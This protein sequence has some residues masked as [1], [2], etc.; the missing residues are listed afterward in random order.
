[1]L[2]RH[3]IRVLGA[4]EVWLG[5]EPIAISGARQRLIVGALALRPGQVVPIAELIDAVWGEDPPETAWRQVQNSVSLLR[6]V[7]DAATLRSEPPGY[8]LAVE[9]EQI[10]LWRF[11]AGLAQGRSLA[12]EGLPVRAAQ[13]FREA[14]LL[15]RGPAFA[16]LGGNLEQAATQ[17][18]AE[19]LAAQEECLE[20]ELL[21][22]AGD[23]LIPELSALVAENPLRERFAAALMLA[24]YRSG[25]QAE[26]LDVYRAAV[27]AL[28]DEL[29][30]DPGPQLSQRHRQILHADPALLAPEATVAAPKPMQLP[31]APPMFVG[32]EAELEA[33]ASGPALTVISGGAGV[34]KTALALHWGH[35]VSGRFPDGQLYVNLCGFDPDGVAVDPAEAVRGFLDA[36]EVGPQRIPVGLA[37]QA[38][39]LR[40]LLSGKRLLIVLDNARDSDQ[41]RHLL[42]GAPGP[43]VIVTSRNLLTG[44]MTTHGARPLPLDLLTAGDAV[45]LLAGRLGE[46]RV[47]AEPDAVRQIVDAC[48]G[49][50]LALAIVAARAVTH[51][52]W[53][54][55]DLAA[56]LA[57][58]RAR[59]D[60]LA[61]DSAGA[62]VRAV[63]SWS[64]LS[65]HPAAARMFRLLGAHPGPEFNA[66]AAASLAAQA[67]AT[68]AEPATA[69]LNTP[70][71][72]SLASQTPTSLAEPAVEPATASPSEPAASRARR[73]LDELADANLLTQRAPGR[74]V[75]HDLLRLY[76]Q[77]LVATNETAEERLA[78]S[79]RLIDH[80]LHTA[81]QADRRLMPS[82]RPIALP[83]PS[84]GTVVG[85]FADYAQAMAWFTTEHAT[86][87][88]CVTHA[89][90][91]R[92]DDRT[93]RLAWALE[94]YLDIRGHWHDLVSTHDTA[95]AA[96]DRLGDPMGQAHAHRGLA[97]AF[98]PLNRLAESLRQLRLAHELHEQL[99]DTI[100]QADIEVSM[101]VVAN[102]QGDY[103]QAL[104]HCVTA[105]KQYDTANDRL[106][107][108]KAHS[109]MGW[110]HAQL[111]DHQQAIEDC[112]YAL[113]LFE[114]L[115]DPN[116][117][118]ATLDS[119]GFA[120]HGLGD[121][122]AALASYQQALALFR[123][124][125]SGLNMA[126]ALDH[127]AG[128]EEAKGRHEAAQ[129]AW[130]EAVAILED[131]D[132]PD[133]GK[134]RQ[135]LE[136]AS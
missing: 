71:A 20:H 9:P 109:A 128:I 14:L 77:E 72:A 113:S 55:A 79:S 23:S 133:A 7:F 17:L 42:P 18:A 41:L 13:V 75:M 106:G 53:S 37:A 90:A 117:H 69:A 61:A 63:F 58:S 60:L 95:L 107:K 24:L 47:A 119:L 116:W 130:L 82:R 16:G 38:A 135:K 115:D 5:R 97:R 86:L 112:R 127:I 36:F 124:S 11:R 1:M 85:S 22:G 89:S 46:A 121:L 105:A 129:R 87:M 94:I 25:R 96:A 134:I 70:A 51:P 131:L 49:L 32:R 93:W 3:D 44:L 102:R 39:M 4:V 100:G 50:P 65:L 83:P 98:A 59:L 88:A 84:P 108:A 48:A 80:Y 35:S 2:E 8:R 73:L 29:G 104:A 101:A 110:Y 99:G 76:A 10:D 118:A 66:P 68:F 43:T 78:A 6:R 27:E 15:W 123:R 111:G 114:G 52:R 40:S 81:V 132:H 54:L 33:L 92:L 12:A 74:Y 125:G 122:D 28:A 30:V 57:D 62:D 21:A 34:G 31:G 67:P 64:Y 103:V 56:A 45:R 91:Q 120:Q 136:R 26:A 126:D 19:R